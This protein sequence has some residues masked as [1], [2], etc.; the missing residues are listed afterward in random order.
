MSTEAIE[1]PTHQFSPEPSDKLKVY[2][3]PPMLPAV[4][5]I[6][7]GNPDG[8]KKF[9]DIGM[10]QEY[11][12]AVYICSD[13][14]D[15]LAHA[16]EYVELERFEGLQRAFAHIKD[17]NKALK[18]ELANAHRALDSLSVVRPDLDIDGSVSDETLFEITE[19]P[20]RL[21]TEREDDEQGTD[22]SDSERGPKDST[23]PTGIQL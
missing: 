3:S 5:W 17:E 21:V 7:N 2:L 19:T 16:L 22:E 10:Q 23:E 4:C 6:C 20:G 14:M 18:E 15:P 13:C 8:V 9:F 1:A 12:G 11:Y